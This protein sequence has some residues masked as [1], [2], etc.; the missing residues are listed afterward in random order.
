MSKKLVALVLAVALVFSTFTTAFAGEALPVDAQA[1]VTIGMLQGD[2][3]AGVTNQYLTTAPDRLQ[4]AIMYLR[5]KGLEQ[6]AL[7]YTSTENF[8]DANEEAW[9]GGRNVMAYLKANPQLG[10]QGKG[11]NLFDPNKDMEA[12]DYY[13]VMLEALGYKQDVDFTYAGLL[14]FA[15]DLGL[16][17]VAGATNFTVANLATATIEALKATVKGSTK[18]LAT[19]LVEAGVIDAQA[20]AAAELYVPAP[21]VAKIDSAVALSSKVVSVTLDEATTAVKASM[22]T[23]VDKDGKAVAVAAAEFAPW[24]DDNTEV[25]L[26]IG[27]DLVAGTLYT[28]KSGETKANFGGIAAETVKP[29]ATVASTDYNE[30]TVTFSEPV[31]AR[32]LAFSAAEK[33]GSKAALS[34]SLKEIKSATQVVFTTDAQKSA[35]LYSTVI[36]G[37]KDFAGN[38][39][40]KD[41]AQTFVG[42]AINTSKQGLN[43]VTVVDSTTIVVGFDVKVNQTTALNPANYVIA[44]KYGSKAAVAVVAAEMNL[45]ANDNVIPTEVKLT[46]GANTKSGTL[47]GLEVKNVGTVYGYALNTDDDT[48]TFVGVD[49]DAK[50]PNAVAVT[51]DSNTQITV[52]FSD[53]NGADNLAAD[54]DYTLVSVNEKYGSKAALALTF[55]EVKNNTIVFTTAAQKAATLYEVKVAAGIEDKAGNVSTDALTTTFVGSVVAEKIT[56]IDA[57]T[58]NTAA[59]ETIIVDF[60]RNYGAGALDVASY[61]IDG[62][63]GYPTKVEAVTGHADQVKLTVAKTSTGKLYELTVKGVANSDGVAMDAEG[64]SKTFVGLGGAPVAAAKLEGAVALNDQ[65]MV[66]YFDQDIED[67]AGLDTTSAAALAAEVALTSS[68]AQPTHAFVDVDN[69]K[70]IVVYTTT[71][72]GFENASGTTV[73]VAVANAGLNASNDEVV[74]AENTTAPT[75]IKVDGVVAVNNTTLNV[76]FNQPIRHLAAGFASVNNGANAITNVRALNEE[77]T[78]W[79]VSLTTAL[80]NTQYTFDLAA[81]NNTLISPIASGATLAG[82]DT[83]TSV[84]FA[85]N[86]A[87]DLYVDEIY[88]VATD[89]RTIKVFYPEDMNVSDVENVANYSVWSAATAGTNVTNG[90]IALAKW[91]DATNTVT[92][93]T[94]GNFTTSTTGYFLRIANTVENA[95]GT[96]TVKVSASEDVSTEFAL[97]TTAPAKL[98]VDSVTASGQTIT[99]KFNQ[100]FTTTVDIS[101]AAELVKYL[102]L[103]VNSSTVLTD[104][105][106]ATVVAKLGT[107]SAVSSA[108]NPVDTLVITVGAGTTLA[109][110]GQ[111]TVELVDTASATAVNGQVQDTDMTPVIFVQK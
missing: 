4:A 102:K 105:D 92:L 90:V 88:A 91:D 17:K 106:I 25:I 18:T 85:G 61:F 73:T 111:G 56:A 109:A 101:T 42:Q 22:F 93:T 34:V 44:E 29:T 26:T 23:V 99:V 40:D 50:K 46:L 2:S 84:A 72:N 79:E 52:S 100:Q 86:A 81:Y 83:T 78:L 71:A 5:L 60:N 74:M 13:K 64:I 45:D 80:T 11:G 7:A 38:A 32:T 89:S 82:L 51:S 37:V 19:A 63:I 104:A 87:A 55:K 54:V 47:Y 62:G 75:A 66:L 9:Q 57:V 15:A 39:M 94:N 36:S 33:Y 35:T 30:V 31:D 68:N 3:S 21:V 58:D 8:A 76:Y 103:T 14:E 28:V 97:S 43:T 70:A 24:N 1:A 59:T 53:E 108:A 16:S 110:N 49:A 10:W 27:T 107:G 41:E 95:L 48:T 98:I 96:K 6:E 65:A 20:A 77:K 12:Q 67:I 69:A